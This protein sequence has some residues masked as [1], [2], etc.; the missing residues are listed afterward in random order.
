MKNADVGDT[1]PYE[2]ATAIDL[3]YSKHGLNITEIKI[4]KESKEYDACSFMIQDKRILFRTAKTTPTKTGQFVTIWKRNSKGIT[5]P[6]DESDAIDF[7]IISSRDGK[8]FGQ[9]IF[10]KSILLI[11]GILANSGKSGKRGIRVYPPW[12]IV[13][14]KQANDTQ[15]WQTKHFVNIEPNNEFDQ[16]RMET[17]FR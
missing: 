17:L 6:F 5:Q 11:K 14:S 3:C 2:L 8:N 10:P 4:E 13:T 15:T 1:I 9:F 16:N 7:F 12:S